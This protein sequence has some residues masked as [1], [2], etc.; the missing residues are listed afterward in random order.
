MGDLKVIAY[1]L[2]YSMWAVYVTVMCVTG[3]IQNPGFVEFL[4]SGA[5][6]IVLMVLP[7]VFSGK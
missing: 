4:I 5:V 1:M 2:C 7:G 6:W 3:F